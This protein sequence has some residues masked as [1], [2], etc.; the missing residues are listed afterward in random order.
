MEET[1]TA[2]PGDGKYTVERKTIL[3]RIVLST[4]GIEKK[5]DVLNSKIE[6][7]QEQI[8]SLYK[9]KEAPSVAKPRSVAK[10][11]ALV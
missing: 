1:V 8:I 10:R 11:A 3:N 5:L 9:Q 6:S 2:I 4:D 7:L